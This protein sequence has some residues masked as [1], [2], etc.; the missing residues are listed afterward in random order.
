MSIPC[1]I[2]FIVVVLD[3]VHVDT[4]ARKPETGKECEKT[5]RHVEA[6]KTQFSGIKNTTCCVLPAQQARK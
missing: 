5:K 1:Y 6:L 3:S 2:V 4:Q